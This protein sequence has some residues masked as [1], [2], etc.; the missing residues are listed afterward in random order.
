M[1]SPIGRSRVES[2]GVIASRSSVITA[3]CWLLCIGAL[4]CFAQ[5][6]L[7]K[8]SE[9]MPNDAT[10]YQVE[11]LPAPRSRLGEGPVW[12]IE[13]KSLFYV[14]IQTPAVL[15]YDYAAKRT[16]SAT[17]EGATTISFIALV[18]GQPDH[19]VVGDDNRVSLI[20][21]NGRSEQANR[22]RTLVDLGDSQRH[23]RFNDGKVDP[24]GRLY[25]GTMQLD[26]LGD[27]YVQKEG[28]LFRYE[29]GTMVV[30]K[31]N[32]SISNG[33]TWDEPHNPRR[34]FYIDSAA[35]D[36]KAFD[37][38][39]NGDL[40]NET[41]F[42]DLRTNGS[43]PGYVGDG[44][45]SDADGNLYVATWGGSKVMKIDKSSQKVVLE[46]KLPTEQI[47]SVAFGGPQ[48]D[49]LFV[50]TSL[51]GGK[52]APAGALFRVTGLGVKGKPM[53]KMIL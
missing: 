6:T 31:Q 40:T 33:L 51:N 11:Q 46:I 41:V 18:A 28:Q 34:M 27:P 13:S 25:A 35:L 44:M 48:L 39:D 1:M 12:D 30:Q 7:S 4:E 19:F 29:N 53:H 17:L 37:V 21:W 45:T 49:E 9:T 24:T 15:R 38:A 32:I 14:D 50:T 3:L 43:D 36:V 16:F 22:V 47:T 23:V 52:P 20:S 42:Y 26:T 2:Q 5:G 8:P 10:Y